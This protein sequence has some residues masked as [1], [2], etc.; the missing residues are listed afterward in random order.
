MKETYIYVYLLNE[1]TGKYEFSEKIPTKGTIIKSGNPGWIDVIN[2]V[3]PPLVRRYPAFN[4]FFS[5]E[6]PNN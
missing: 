3:Y 1:D 6:A 4:V 5:Y 2:T